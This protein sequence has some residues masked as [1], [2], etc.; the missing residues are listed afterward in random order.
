VLAPPVTT[1]GEA[2]Q[3]KA[4]LKQAN[5]LLS[6][7]ENRYKNKVGCCAGRGVCGGGV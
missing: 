3:L 6:L 2:A 1:G 5:A 4:D 7:L